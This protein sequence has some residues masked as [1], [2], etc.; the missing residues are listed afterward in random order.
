MSD[1]KMTGMV[2]FATILV[3]VV[4]GAVVIFSL[5]YYKQ[6]SQALTGPP[7]HPAPHAA[8]ATHVKNVYVGAYEPGAPMTF[9]PYQTFAKSVTKPNI[10][11]YYSGWYENFHT[12]FAQQAYQNGATVLVQME[13][14]GISMAAIANGQYDWYLHSFAKRVRTFQHPVII[15]F[16]HEMNGSW[17]TWGMKHTPP[18][19]WV[20]AWKHVVTVFRQ[21]GADNV[22]WLWTINHAGPTEQKYILPYWPGDNYVT[23]IGLDGYYYSPQNTYANVFGPTIATIRKLTKKPILL[24]EMAI[25]PTANQAVKIP[26]LFAGIKQDHLLGLVWFDVAQHGGL[27]RQNWKLEQSPASIAAFRLGVQ[28]LQGA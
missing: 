25:G 16:A 3:V 7:I 23:W 22:T 11:I 2:I 14:N 13:P 9:A 24:S 26:G 6:Q 4:A 27:Y 15:G 18:S 12:T 17:Y 8:P 10:V 5:K 1:R 19:E 20:A 28:S 21:A